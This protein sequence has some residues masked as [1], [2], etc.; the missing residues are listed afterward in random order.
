M[1]FKKYDF[2]SGGATDYDALYAQV[3]AVLGDLTPLGKDCGVL[4]DAI[5]CKGDASSGMRL[6]PHEKTCLDTCDAEG[7]IL[8]V[9]DGTCDRAQRPLACRI[10]P[11]FP[12]ID[13]RGRIFVEIDARAKRMCPIAAHSEMVKF[14]R[15]FIRAVKKVGE[16]LALDDECREFLH[17]TTEEIDMIAQFYDE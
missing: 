14:D 15:R 12:T 16:L 10:F 8:A 1:L 11:M 3:F 6:F 7:G 17:Q 4:C 2:V 9:C 5:C 13:E